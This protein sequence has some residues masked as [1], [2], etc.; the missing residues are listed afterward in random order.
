MNTW[1]T[2]EQAVTILRGRGFFLPL[3]LVQGTETGPAGQLVVCDY[4]SLT[5]YD[6]AWQIAVYSADGERLVERINVLR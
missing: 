6:A 5:E 4:R 3:G 2:K 1:V